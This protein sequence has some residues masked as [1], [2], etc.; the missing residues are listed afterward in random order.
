MVTRFRSLAFGCTRSA[1]LV[2]LGAL[3]I[4][5]SAQAVHAQQNVYG[6]YGPGLTAAKRGH[7]P[8]RWI[9]GPA[10]PEPLSGLSADC[11]RIRLELCETDLGSAISDR[12][13]IQTVKL[14]GNLM[15]VRTRRVAQVLD[16]V[17]ADKS[18]STFACRASVVRLAL[19]EGS[20]HYRLLWEGQQDEEFY[21]LDHIATA[22]HPEGTILGFTYCQTGTGGCW[23]EL[24]ISEDGVAWG[25][26]EKDKSWAAVYGGMPRGYRLHKSPLI[27]LSALTWKRAMARRD[28][29]N[30]CPSGHISM[31]LAIRNGRLAI[32]DYRYVT[33][34]APEKR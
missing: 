14:R 20:D 32:V 12:C 21:V 7:A 8:G 5:A 24:Y 22:V 16:T 10:R 11:Q 31:K 17:P 19:Q 28:D 34:S 26:L 6:A 18:A 13:S 9:S 2:L 29:P 15:M 4:G 30:C 23:Q 25:P 1:V 3:T 27:D 33:G